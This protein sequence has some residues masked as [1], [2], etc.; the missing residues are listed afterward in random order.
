[1][2][3]ALHIKF[4]KKEKEMLYNYSQATFT[5][6][7]SRYCFIFNNEKHLNKDCMVKP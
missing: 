3:N 5:T 7:Y 6:N 1:M 2:I 4:V